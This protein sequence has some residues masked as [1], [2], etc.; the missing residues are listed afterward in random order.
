MAGRDAEHG[1]PPERWAAEV[2]NKWWS[3]ETH[4]SEV[5]WF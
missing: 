4:F 3:C 2:C 1:L 5:L